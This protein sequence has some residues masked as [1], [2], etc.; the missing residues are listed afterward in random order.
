MLKNAEDA[1]RSR[2]NL[3]NVVVSLLPDKKHKYMTLQWSRERAQ[4]GESDNT[5]P[6]AIIISSLRHSFCLDSELSSWETRG[7]DV[8]EMCISNRERE[9]RHEKVFLWSSRVKSGSLSSDDSW[10]KSL[11]SEWLVSY[12]QNVFI[13]WMLQQTR[14]ALKM[15]FCVNTSV[16]SCF[17]CVYVSKLLPRPPDLTLQVEEDVGGGSSVFHA[18]FWANVKVLI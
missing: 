12:Q 8:L 13:V 16:I 7:E 3:W 14:A 18:H 2:P 17:L 11:L 5:F 4:E 6:Y 15:K 1:C 10:L 9:R